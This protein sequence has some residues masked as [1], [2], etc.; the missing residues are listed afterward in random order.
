MQAIKL[1]HYEVYYWSRVD[2]TI[3]SDIVLQDNVWLSTM[4]MKKFVHYDA[5]VF[6]I[7]SLHFHK[8]QQIYYHLPLETFE[9]SYFPRFI[10]KKIMSPI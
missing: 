1:I 10:P 9:K 7:S 2:E 8:N 5:L 3:I 6:L 4:R